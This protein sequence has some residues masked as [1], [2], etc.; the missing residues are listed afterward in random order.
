MICAFYITSITDLFSLC[1]ALEQ[2]TLHTTLLDTKAT[3]FLMKFGT[4]MWKV[5]LCL[6]KALRKVVGSFVPKDQSS[7]KK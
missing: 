4:V 1:V 3:E 7:A 6:V 5:S 2:N